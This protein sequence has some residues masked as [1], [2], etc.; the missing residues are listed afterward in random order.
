MT[1]SS[2]CGKMFV[3]RIVVS[4]LGEK[5]TKSDLEAVFRPFGDVSVQYFSNTNN[6]LLRYSCPDAAHLAI[7]RMNLVTLCG[8]ILS[9]S[10]STLCLI[11][12][13]V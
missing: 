3:C 9:V 2:E 5:C 6:A 13:P 8:C 11:N 1:E 10:I 7:Q 12:E 4:N